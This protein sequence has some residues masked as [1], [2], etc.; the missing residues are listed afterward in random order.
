MFYDFF[1][2]IM[3]MIYL[4]VEADNSDVDRESR[5]L[6]DLSLLVTSLLKRSTLGPM[7]FRVA[8]E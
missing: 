3:I 6:T 8:S 7:L 5:E 2:A 4:G 1:L